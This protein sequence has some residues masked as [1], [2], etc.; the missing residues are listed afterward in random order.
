MKLQDVSPILR[1]R[2]LHRSVEFYTGLLGFECDAICEQWH[3]ASVKRDGV[4]VMFSQPGPDDEDGFDGPVFTGSLYFYPDDV[5]VAWNQL[6]DKVR[7]S[8]PIEDFS[9]GMREFGIYDNNGYLLQFGQEIPPAA[10]E[11]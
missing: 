5:D 4:T 2:D 9:Y 3:W 7:V 1:T 6:R 10:N 8:Y 11:A